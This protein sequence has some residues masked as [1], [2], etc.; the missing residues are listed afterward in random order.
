MSAHVVH[1]FTVCS[2]SAQVAQIRDEKHTFKSFHFSHMVFKGDVTGHITAL[3]STLSNTLT[4]H[5]I[6][7]T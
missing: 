7:G 4:F 2:N 6:Y 1:T 3:K 5:F